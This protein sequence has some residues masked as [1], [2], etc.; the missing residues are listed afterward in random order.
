[1]IFLHRGVSPWDGAPPGAPPPP[2]G[3]WRPSGSLAPARRTGAPWPPP[4][5]PHGQAQQQVARCP[6]SR[7]PA[8]PEHSWA[9]RRAGLGPLGKSGFAHVFTSFAPSPKEEPPLPFD[10]LHPLCHA[11]FLLFCAGADRCAA[12][13]PAPGLGSRPP[14]C[15]I[16]RICP[17]KNTPPSGGWILFFPTVKKYTHSRRILALHF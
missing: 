8:R 11:P 17:W 9:S 16:E 10:G 4:L 5:C 1:M 3:R 7:G 2:C 15:E 13:R 14:P 6:H 12:R